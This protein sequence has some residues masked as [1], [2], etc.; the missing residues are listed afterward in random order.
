MQLGVFIPIG[1]NGWL[2][3]TTSPQ[4]MPT[5]DLNRTIVEKAERFGFDFALSMIKLHGFG[6]PSQFWDHNLESFTLMAG[7]ASVTQRIQLFATCAV[8]TMPP[9]IAARMAV[10]IDSISHGRFGVNIISGWQR[11]EYTQM[12]IWPG[13]EHYKRRYE[14]CAEYVTIMRELWEA[15][16]SDFKGEF[17]K[18]D[19]CRCSPLPT[20]RIPII[21]AAQSDAGTRYAAEH[22]DYN[23]CAS[24]GENKPSAVA[25]SVA[26]LVAANKE[27][28]RDCGALV[29]TM[30]I[31]DETD[32]AAIAKW[33][34]YKDG[35]DMEAIAHRDAQAKD[36]PNTDIYSQPNRRALAGGDKLPTNQGVLV[37]SYASVARML[38]EMS[39][40]PGVRGVMLTF[41]DFVVGMEQFGTRIMPLMRCLEKTNKAA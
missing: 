32:A 6:G 41:D 38:D 27:T 40:V 31:A 21:C 26:R 4:Y 24:F 14:Y 1:N 20:S 25:P 11:R 22:A 19:D 33:Q 37:G 13:A 15:G 30:I 17:F 3:S 10:T 9:P 28:G 36:D 18:M 8:L 39:A 35:T 5:F 23:F 7:L 2:I 29:L 16:R 12:G 34:H